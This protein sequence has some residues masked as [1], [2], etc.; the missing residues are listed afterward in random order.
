MVAEN[1]KVFGENDTVII[2]IKT[3]LGRHTVSGHWAFRVYTRKKI[4]KKSYSMP[5]IEILKYGYGI[6]NIRDKVASSCLQW[7]DAEHKILQIDLSSCY[8]TSEDEIYLYVSV[9]DKHQLY[10][11]EADFGKIF[12]L[13]C[14]EALH[15]C[16]K[17]ATTQMGGGPHQTTVV[18]DVQYKKDSCM[19]PEKK[20]MPYIL[21]WVADDIQS[22]DLT[23]CYDL[24][25]I[26]GNIG[27]VKLRVNTVDVDSR[28]ITFYNFPSHFSFNDFGTN[29]FT[30]YKGAMLQLERL[31]KSMNEK[32]TMTNNTSLLK[33]LEKL[34]QI[35]V[36]FGPDTISKLLSTDFFVAPASSHHHGAVP[37]GL[38]IHSDDVAET[39]QDFTDKMGLKWSRPE[40]PKI[41][42]YLHDLCKIDS[43]TKA[44]DWTEKNPKYVYN[45][46]Q[47]IPGH[48]EKSLVLAQQLDISLTHEEMM[49]IR[50]HMGA[51]DD[52]GNWE[53]YRRAATKY[54]NILWTAQADILVAY[55]KDV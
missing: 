49:C 52:K 46:E 30:T 47:L 41:V 17:I 35:D 29:I 36:C 54:P 44:E 48:G 53:F 4:K 25:Y 5:S 43:Y 1:R 37:E 12:F 50:W 19:I 20:D 55:T 45:K 21:Y 23:G 42:G 3:S 26:R 11:S 18:R 27:I 39:L 31:E 16:E 15:V 7:A 40:S 34:K 8:Y 24:Y 13:D 22:R 9:A 33:K 32:I 2:K 6:F 14:D 28:K 51:F 10:Y 38:W